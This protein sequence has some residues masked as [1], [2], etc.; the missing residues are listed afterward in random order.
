MNCMI[1][2]S[3]LVHWWHFVPDN[4]LS[5]Q[6]GLIQEVSYHTTVT[7]PGTS[8]TY[9]WFITFSGCIKDFR[10]DWRYVLRNGVHKQVDIPVKKKVKSHIFQGHAKVGLCAF[11]FWL[12]LV[13]HKMD[14]MGSEPVFYCEEASFTFPEQLEK[15]FKIIWVLEWGMIWRKVRLVQEV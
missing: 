11:H 7:W 2:R 1:L 13:V 8:L 5:W 12:Y 10:P 6:K 3:G 9:L 4:P 15:V 14:S